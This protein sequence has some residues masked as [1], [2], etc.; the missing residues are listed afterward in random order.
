MAPQATADTILL[1][2]EE[3]EVSKPT[4]VVHLCSARVHT[5]VAY[6][7]ACQH[8]CIRVCMC[9]CVRL[10]SF[11]FLGGG[12]VHMLMCMPV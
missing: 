4:Y 9:V 2:M 12:H 8:A 10:L 6:V 3:D 11:L 7:H 1:G 5:G